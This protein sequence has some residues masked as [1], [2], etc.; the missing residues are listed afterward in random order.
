L[1]IMNSQE[2]IIAAFRGEQPDRVP[3]IF[4]LNLGMIR[5]LV[6]GQVSLPE[7]FD[8][9]IENPLEAETSVI[10]VQED[11]GLDPIVVTASHHFGEWETWPR[12][13]LSYPP[14]ATENWRERRSVIEKASDSQALKIRRVIQTPKG[15]LSYSYQVKDGSCWP[16]EYLIKAEEDVKLLEYWPDPMRMDIR[17][18]KRMVDT[19]G[20]RAFF[21]HAFSAVWNEAAELRGPVNLAMDI[22]ERP[23]WVKELL[24]IVKRRQIRHV[25]RLAETGIHAIAYM[26]DWLGMGISPAAYDEFI[27]PYDQE[28]IQ[29]AHEAG[30]LVSYHVCGRGSVLLERITSTGPDA[31]ETLTPREKSGDFD[32]AEC[33]ARVGDRI[34]LFGGF[35]ERVLDSDDPQMV[36]HEVRRCLDAAK[37]GG[38]YI[39]HGTGQLFCFRSQNIRVM[40]ETIQEH[41]SYL[42]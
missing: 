12:K 17:V 35:D 6:P 31:L 33:K 1:G 2:R 19:V 29:T 5:Q 20:K 42:R 4:R 30:L 27:G 15:D 41:G 7:M 32:L 34:C 28:I 24:D 3:V 18:L 38:R 9:W 39:L 26:Q 21:R 22:Y 10:R 14:T 8:Q 13:L 16:S 36:Q 11:L 25:C 37:P 23:G 40:L